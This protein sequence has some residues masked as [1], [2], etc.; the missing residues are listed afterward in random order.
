[1]AIVLLARLFYWQVLRRDDVLRNSPANAAGIGAA[2]WRG[3]IYDC[4]GH[5]LAVPLLV[6]DVGVTP[7][8]V[9]DPVQVAGLL[10]PLLNLPET[11]LSA[12]LSQK[13]VPWLPLAQGLSAPQGQA[14]KALHLL[15]LQLDVRPGRYYPEGRLAAAVLGFV[16]SEQRGYYGLEEYYDSRLRGSAGSAAG[17]PQVLLDLPFVQAPRN[18]ADL[19]LTLDRVVQQAAEKNL[20][21]ALEAYQAQSGVIIVMDPH[22]GAILGLATAPSYDPNAFAEVQSSEA[23]VDTAISRPYEPGSVFKVV[24]MA[25]ALDAGVIRPEDTYVDDGRVEVGNRVF[26]NWDRQA[27][28]RVTMTQI[29]AYSL[30]TGAIHVAMKLGQDRFYEAVRRF[31]FGEAT[32][33]DLAGEVAGTVRVPG[34][35]Y[36]SISDLAANSFGQGLAVTPLQMVTA[37]AA[38]ANKGALMR[39]YVVDQIVQDGQVV[40]Q[41]QPQVVRQ[42]IAPQ[43]AAEL[44]DMLVNALPQE[45]PLGVVPHYTAAGKTGT[46]QVVVNGQYDDNTVIASFAGYLPANDPRFVVLVKLDRPQRE[47][48]GSRSAAP[49]WRNLASE[50]CA[51]LGVPPDQATVY[52]D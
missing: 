9:T 40:W 15:G 25:A 1:M 51:Y 43:V 20:Q 32:G 14:I 41:A 8:S 48:W 39:P 50:L 16:N 3:S 13:D 52:G 35:P 10:A 44:T 47:A 4:H 46:A 26:W 21:Q 31:G 33:I 5:F 30:N 34:T 6:Y 2:A 22:T 18:G 24:T 42:V 29:L 36:W 28:G 7:R 49:V 23:Y 45:T 17:G 37:I 11:E 12:K 27:H 38:V 19:I